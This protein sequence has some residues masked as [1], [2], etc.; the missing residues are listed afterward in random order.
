MMGHWIVVHERRIAIGVSI[1][2]SSLCAVLLL[3]WSGA[4]RYQN[5]LIINI[6]SLAALTLAFAIPGVGLALAVGVQVWRKRMTPEW[7]LFGVYGV[8]V[9]VAACV[10]LAIAADCVPHCKGSRGS[11]TVG[12]MLAVPAGLAAGAACYWVSA[13][14]Q[15]AL[16]LMNRWRT[17]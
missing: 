7:F 5:E 1:F 16:R 3:V 6:I 12:L 13:L 2:L 9:S 14:S 15:V 10:A 8:A 11:L 17:Q 4:A